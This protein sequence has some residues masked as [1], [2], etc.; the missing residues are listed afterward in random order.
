MPPHR[1]R[2]MCSTGQLLLSRRIALECAAG[3][4]SRL[5]GTP[6]G[7]YSVTEPLGGVLQIVVN[8]IRLAPEV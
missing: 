7:A 4:G 8:L 3:L 1:P 5:G 2:R 6:P